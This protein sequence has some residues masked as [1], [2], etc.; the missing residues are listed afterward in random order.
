[1]YNSIER[2]S[3]KLKIILNEIE[4]DKQPLPLT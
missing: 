3:F 1:M 4:V 2:G